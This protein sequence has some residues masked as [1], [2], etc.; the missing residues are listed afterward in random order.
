MGWADRVADILRRVHPDLA[1]ANIAEVGATTDAAL[2]SQAGRMIDFGPDLVHLPCAANDLFEQRPDF[3][4][5]EQTLR[6]L[7]ELAAGT[8]A[9]L[10]T[11]T[12]G[13]A[14]VVPK[15]PDWPDRVRA[16]NDITR[17]LA[18]EFDAVLVDAWDHPVNERKDL[19]SADRI[20]F[21]AAG[22]AV[23]AAEMVKALAELSDNRIRAEVR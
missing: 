7:Y 3:D 17:R 22:Q 18:A 4:E 12:L 9:Q 11:F 15:Y 19:L 20:H 14:F 10:T 16:V 8:G 6:R 2:R 1:Y 21:A 13:R 5:I 23:L